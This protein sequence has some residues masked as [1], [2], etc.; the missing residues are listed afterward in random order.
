MKQVTEHS[1][2]EP[3][4]EASPQHNAQS[5]PQTTPLSDCAGPFSPQQHTG[6]LQHQLQ[7]GVL[8]I[9]TA[10]VSATHRKQPG[11]CLSP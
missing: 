4:T 3:Q 5:S 8:L 11:L 9:D 6:A 10:H 7:T 1:Q 2:A